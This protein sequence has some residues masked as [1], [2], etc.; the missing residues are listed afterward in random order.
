MADSL[1]PNNADV[2]DTWGE[3]SMAA[4]R[5][6]DAVN[7]FERAIKNDSKR[8]DIRKKLIAAYRAAG[9]NAM[10]ATQLELVQSLESV[11][12]SRNK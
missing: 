5:P 2:L 1:C 8:I 12:I 7:K 4:N 6:R 9:L 3:V 11:A 10:A